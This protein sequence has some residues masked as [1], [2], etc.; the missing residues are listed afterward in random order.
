MNLGTKYMKS[1]GIRKKFLKQFIKYNEFR[2]E[3]YEK[4][5]YQKKIFK[6]VHKI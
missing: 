3:I 2:H 6:T 1:S 4:F 5:W